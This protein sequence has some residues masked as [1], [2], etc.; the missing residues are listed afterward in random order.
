MEKTI[1]LNVDEAFLL[2]QPLLREI[3]T[4]RDV[5]SSDSHADIEVQYTGF[6]AEEVEEEIF[7]PHRENL[8]N[9]ES[10]FIHMFGYPAD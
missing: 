9:L 6:S 10:L 8:H 4:A 1:T 5:V 7:K 3:E 2:F